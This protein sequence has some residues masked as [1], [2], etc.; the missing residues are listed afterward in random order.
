MASNTL[1]ALAF[2][3][4]GMHHPGWIYELVSQQQGLASGT[5]LPD[6]PHAERNATELAVEP[7]P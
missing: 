2:R 3:P 6:L 4:V 5:N 7:T 1:N